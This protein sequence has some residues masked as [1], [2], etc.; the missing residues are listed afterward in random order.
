MGQI[1]APGSRLMLDFVHLSSLSGSVW[2]PGLESS[3]IAVAN[4]GE[5]WKSGF[6]ERPEAVGALMQLFGFDSVELL[7]AR[8]MVER[9]A[10]GAP[11]RSHPPSIPPYFGYIAAGKQ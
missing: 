6:D 9:F 2:H 10:P 8:D 3:C 4:K 1:S 5:S 7:T 11:Y